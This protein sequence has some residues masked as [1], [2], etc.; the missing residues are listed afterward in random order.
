[1]IN[2]CFKE[3]KG[4]KVVHIVTIKHRHFAAVSS[5]APQASRMDTLHNNASYLK[6]RNRRAHR[7][8]EK[9]KKRKVK[10][11]WLDE[12]SPCVDAETLHYLQQKCVNVIY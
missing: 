6:C 7:L 1:M 12:I 4:V 3:C 2:R 11:D 9:K 5:G 10:I 8:Q